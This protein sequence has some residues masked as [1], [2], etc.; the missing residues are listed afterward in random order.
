MNRS[1]TL[2]CE[3]TVDLPFSYVDGRDI[4]VLF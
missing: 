3:S 4:P 2:S 1:F